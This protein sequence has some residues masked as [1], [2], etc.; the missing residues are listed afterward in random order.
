[1]AADA[2]ACPMRAGSWKD[3]VTLCEFVD[4]ALCALMINE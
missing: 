3:G 1:M 4:A 2:P